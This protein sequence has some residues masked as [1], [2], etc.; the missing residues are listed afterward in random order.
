M[1]SGSAKINYI[2]TLFPSFEPELKQKLAD[3]AVLKE[4][5]AGELLMQTG[6]YFRATILVVKGNI[7]LYFL[8]LIYRWL[9]QFNRRISKL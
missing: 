4:V 5:K 6:Q 7:K 8:F 1:E 9:Y 2:N 3:H